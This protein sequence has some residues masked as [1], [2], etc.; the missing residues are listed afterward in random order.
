MTD[1]TVDHPLFRKFNM[2]DRDRDR[3]LVEFDY[4]PIDSFSITLGYIHAKSQYKESVLGLQKSVD[5][6]YSVNLNYAISSTVNAYAFYNLDYLDAD[7]TNTAGGN[8]IPWNAE[9]QDRI[10]TAGIGL[11]AVH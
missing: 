4:M 9:T 3:M 8:S 1:G 5:E 2:A 11:T 10:E 6:S 7:I